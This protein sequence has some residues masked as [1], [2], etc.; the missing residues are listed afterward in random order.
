MGCVYMLTSPSGKSYIG[1]TMNWKR[2][3]KAHVKMASTKNG[4]LI[5]NAIR[6]YGWDNFTK[7]ILLDSDD[8]EVLKDAERTEIQSRQ[9]HCSQS[10]YNLTF[11][12]DGVLGYK[13]STE[14]RKKL[15]ESHLGKTHSPESKE[16]MSKAHKGHQN[17][18]AHNQ[19]ISKAI[20][21]HKSYKKSGT[22]CPQEVKDKIRDKLK[23]RPIGHRKKPPP[24]TE[25]HRQ[26]LREAQARRRAQEKNDPETP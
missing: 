18:P 2:R 3:M 15:R 17:T 20:L 14:T 8:F 9:T 7:T 13:A 22:P 5:H 4:Y 25:E 26:R 19:N 11:G 12:G 1:I 23:G 10:G 24:F 6:K 16:R 21:G